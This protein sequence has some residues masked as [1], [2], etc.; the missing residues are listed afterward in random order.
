MAYYS[1]YEP[2]GKKG[3]LNIGTFTEE[4]LPNVNEEWVKREELLS[5]NFG[6]DDMVE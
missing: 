3:E 2:K 1:S 5:I 6:T 4:E